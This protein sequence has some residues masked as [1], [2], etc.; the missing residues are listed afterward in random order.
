MKRL[1]IHL[2]VQDLAASIRFYNGLFAASPTVQKD[3][4]AK[5]MLDDPKV[6]F[7]I[8]TRDEHVGLNH[9][10]IQ[11]DSA[12]ELLAL[13]ASTAKAGLGAV[14]E[15]GANCCYAQ[16]D[17]QWLTDPQGVIWEAFHT[18]G[19]IPVYGGQP[20]DDGTACCAPKTK[21]RISLADLAG[22]KPNSGCC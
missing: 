8:S 5:W 17:K 14:A 13:E 12:D 7:A 3:D 18:T 2:T 19:E 1:H 4:Y 22:C 10:G 15:V 9:L 6:N 21:P 16:S 20:R 11:V